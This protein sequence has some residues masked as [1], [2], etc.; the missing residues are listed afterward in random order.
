MKRK[1]NLIIGIRIKIEQ[2]KRNDIESIIWWGLGSILNSWAIYRWPRFKRIEN[3]EKL[4]ASLK[5]KLK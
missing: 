1:R 4:I 5:S 2:L 3:Y